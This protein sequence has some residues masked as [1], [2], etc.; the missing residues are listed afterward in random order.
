MK[1][2]V[3]GSPGAAR[4][5]G[6][7]VAMAGTVVAL[8]LAAAPATADESLNATGSIIYTWQGDPSL[9]CA[10]V[11]VCGVQGALTIDAQGD[12]DAL[13]LGPS[14]SINL[15]LSATTVRVRNGAGSSG[16]ECVDVPAIAPANLV[17]ARQAGG[18]LTARI[19]PTPSSG[20]C[21]GPL[22]QDL[23]GLRLPVGKTPGKRP[24]FDL[25]G[26][27]PFV[28]G[29][30]SGTLAS[31]L[32]FTPSS[33]GG[34]ESTSSSG[35][36][37]GLPPRRKVL[38]E[39]VT[40]RYHV[41]SL[42]GTLE[43]SFA[44]EPD[45]FCAALDSCGATG[46]LSLSPA[47]ADGTLTLT[48][49]R[50]VRHRVSSRRTLADFKA[51]RLGRPVGSLF[52]RAG[53]AVVTETY[54]GGDGLRCQDSSSTDVREEMFVGGGGAGR[55]E[56]TVNEPQDAVLLR[57]HC[58]GPTDTDVFGNSA[59]F[60]RGSI[61]L[62]DLLE[63]H[64]AVSLSNSGDFSGVGYVGSR[65]GTIGLSLALQRVRAGTVQEERP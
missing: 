60:V 21:A 23:A 12:A 6:V 44:G 2:G 5:L 41:A 24:S 51:G 61:S 11:G 13:S 28:A 49:V 35:T 53:T 46:T 58:P 1:R 62:R 16:D 8:A 9:G 15:F 45:P 47:P 18:G 40:L 39:Q 22:A 17:I 3:A 34:S 63:R 50:V 57:T 30:F 54:A 19:D 20:R 29:P 26:S 55:V 52:G 42:P 27:Q 33:N 25:R 37:P 59:V 38:V 14:T 48:A 32:V 36:S 64:S 56:V 31:T 65:A 4:A 43:T 10:A 7:A